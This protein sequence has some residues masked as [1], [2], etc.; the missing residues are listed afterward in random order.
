M[1]STYEN[2]RESWTRQLLSTG[3]RVYLRA[4]AGIAFELEGLYLYPVRAAKEIASEVLSDTFFFSFELIQRGIDH[5]LETAQTQM[6][7]RPRLSGR[8]KV[9]NARRITRVAREAL[10]YGIQRRVEKDT[11][12]T[13]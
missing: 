8:S 3:F 11:R 6:I 7:C 12:L 10:R 13:D 2:E 9:A 5:G 4:V 1:L